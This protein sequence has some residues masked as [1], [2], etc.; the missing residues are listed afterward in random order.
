MIGTPA[1][2][3]KWLLDRPQDKTFECKEKRKKRSLSQNDLYWALVTEIANVMRIS[4]SE[5]HNVML[6]RYGQP[7]RIEGRLVAVTIPDTEKAWKQ[8]LLAEEYHV[9]PTSQVKL[10]TKNQMFRTYILLRGSR[11]YDSREM[12]ILIDGTIDEAK[13]LGINTEEWT[14]LLKRQNPVISAGAKET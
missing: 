14:A 12:T 8:A 5:V 9:R 13:Q 3:I 11:T 10:G 7:E 2:L 1:Q 6:R 4:K